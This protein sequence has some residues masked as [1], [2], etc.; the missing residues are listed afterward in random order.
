MSITFDD[1]QINAEV[2]RI[3]N[4]LAILEKRK[5]TDSLRVL[6]EEEGTKK[7]E[8]LKFDKRV[9][10]KAEKANPEPR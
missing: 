3:S 9:R 7:I 1:T 4:E 8:R 5:P 10:A 6:I 2:S